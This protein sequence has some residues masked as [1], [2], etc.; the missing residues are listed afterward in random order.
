MRIVYTNDVHSH[1]T[2][3]AALWRALDEAR[4]QGA[5]VI[6]G[7]DFLEG[8]YFFAHHNG[9]P[10]LQLLDALFDMTCPGNHG[11]GHMRQYNFQR[12]QVICLNLVD[13]DTQTPLFTPY[14]DIEGTIFTAIMTPEVFETIP[15]QERQGLC[16]LDPWSTLAAWYE[17]VSSKNVVVLSHC[18]LDADVS[19]MPVET[20]LK[21]VLSSHCH[22]AYHRRQKA[23]VLMI[24]APEYAQGYVDVHIEADE[25]HAKIVSTP[26]S[27]DASGLPESLSFLADATQQ[28]I[29]MASQ[30]IGHWTHFDVYPNRT[31][32]TRG[33]LESWLASWP[34]ATVGLLNITCMRHLLADGPVTREA[35]YGLFPF[36]NRIVKARV[37]RENYQQ[38]VAR[39][40]HFM[41]GMVV[42]RVVDEVLPEQFILLTSSHLWENFFTTHTQGV[43]VAFIRDHFGV[44]MLNV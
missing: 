7:G 13:A 4:S 6:D 31:E 26:P 34:D 41:P 18:G 3:S 24:K 39:L 8:T 37:T 23:H 17:T 20:K 15:Y 11:F 40:E 14:L 30:V 5:L 12:C 29:Q 44:H 1:L 35:L 28:T 2:Q 25:V 32:L 43:E 16:C 22:S 9:V 10:E 36:G 42:E 33:V 27:E 38:V 21:L 19:M